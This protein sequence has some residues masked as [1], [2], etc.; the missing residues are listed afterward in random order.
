VIGKINEDKMTLEFNKTCGLCLEGNIS[1]NFKLFKQEVVIY[2]KATKT[3]KKDN[4]VQVTRLLNLLGQDGLKI[5][6]TIKKKDGEET[7]NSILEAL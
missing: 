2:F 5:L 3:D 1:E 6:N 7:V 4:D